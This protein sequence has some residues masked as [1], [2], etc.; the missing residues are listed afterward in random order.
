MNFETD[1]DIDTQSLCIL[2]L[3]AVGA[4]FH[5]HPNPSALQDEWLAVI[6]RLRSTDNASNIDV[7]GVC[8]IAEALLTEIPRES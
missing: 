5:T 7:S 2:L 3:D 6:A 4:I 1:H 8:K